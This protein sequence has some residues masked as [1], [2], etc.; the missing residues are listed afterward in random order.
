MPTS[1]KAD[2]VSAT[3]T[4]GRNSREKRKLLDKLVEYGETIGHL[5]SEDARW[6]SHLTTI[7]THLRSAARVER[8]ERE[9]RRHLG[10]EK[11]HVLSFQKKIAKHIFKIRN[12]ISRTKQRLEY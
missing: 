5:S 1:N 2:G 9:M 3:V 11:A 8:S 7:D 4:N 6:R 12:E 10:L